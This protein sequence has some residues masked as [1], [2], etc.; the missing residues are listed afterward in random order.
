M[1]DTEITRVF[2]CGSALRGQP[3]HGTIAETEFLGAVKTQPNYRLHSV[4]DQHPGVYEVETDG[5]AIAGELYAMTPA[6][7]Q[8][9]LDNEPPNLYPGPVTLEDGSDATAMLYPQDLIEANNLPDVSQF[10]GWT[11]YKASLG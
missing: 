2:I 3:D 1:S 6:Q 4:Y 8:H 9:L 10:G 5:I 7:Y 11:A